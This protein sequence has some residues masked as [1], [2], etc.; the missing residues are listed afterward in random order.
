MA[1]LLQSPVLPNG[2]KS[3]KEVTILIPY[4]LVY[5]GFQLCGV[6]QILSFNPL[7]YAHLALSQVTLL[8][9]FP[10]PSEHITLPGHFSSP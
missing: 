9:L 3:N 2:L 10:F 5:M 1:P 6:Y 7:S 8:L 4:S